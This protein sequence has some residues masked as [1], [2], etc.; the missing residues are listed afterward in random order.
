MVQ[1]LGLHA[2]TA[3]GVGSIPGL[4]TK[5]P[6]A[7]QCGQK[8]NNNNKKTPKQKKRQMISFGRVWRIW[9]P[10]TLLGGI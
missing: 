9:N 6:S 1:R 4:G 10:H 2:S 3:G 5:I 7:A 8:E